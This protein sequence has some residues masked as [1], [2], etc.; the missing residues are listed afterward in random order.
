[1]LSLRLQTPM[2]PPAPTASAL[3]D[4]MSDEQKIEWL[5]VEVMGW[6]HGFCRD[7][8]DADTDFFTESGWFFENGNEEAG[9]EWN[10]LTDWNHWRQVEEKFLEEATEDQLIEYTEQLNRK[11]MNRTRICENMMKAD[12]PTSFPEIK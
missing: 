7:E 10:P 4:S 6:E 3:W 9:E 2:K 5:A 1:M 11:N 12:L 8:G